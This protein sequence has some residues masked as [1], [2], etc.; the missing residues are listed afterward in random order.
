[1]PS[2]DVP[3]AV[4]VTEDD[5]IVLPANQLAL[6]EIIPGAKV[7]GVAGDHAVCVADA[8]HFVPVLLRACRSVARRSATPT[9]PATPTAPT[10]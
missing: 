1:L 5:R 3:T 10:T 6:A 8:A 4:V 9:R 2:V 7:F